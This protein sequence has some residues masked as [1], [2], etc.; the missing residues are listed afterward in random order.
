MDAAGRPVEDTRR[1]ALLALVEHA[2]AHGEDPVPHFMGNLLRRRWH[3]VTQADEDAAIA[4]LKRFREPRLT[5]PGIGAT[6]RLL[7]SRAP[8]GSP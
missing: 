6:G 7:G 4:K 1:A 8:H 3:H 2:R 5:L